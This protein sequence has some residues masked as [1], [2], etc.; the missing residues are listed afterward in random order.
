MLLSHPLILEVIS[1]FVASSTATCFYDAELKFNPT[2]QPTPT[3][4]LH[5][6]A[7]TRPLARL[8]GKRASLCTLAH[9]TV[10]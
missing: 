6:A 5:P 8:R 9:S 3:S 2:P 7:C 10:C 4:A 1:S